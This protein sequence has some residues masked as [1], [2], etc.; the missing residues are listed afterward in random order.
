MTVHGFS[1][2]VIRELKEETSS[3]GDRRHVW[4]LWKP[5]PYANSREL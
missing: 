2:G 4:S 5:K 3:Y 1:T